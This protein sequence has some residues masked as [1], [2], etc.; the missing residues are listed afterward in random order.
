M[1]QIRNRWTGEVIAEG[2][3]KLRE[4][5]EKHR[6][7]LGGADL[8]EANLGGADLWGAN[9]R[10]ADLRGA[11][12]DFYYFPSIRTL[13]S[14]TL[15]N[16]SD[17]VTLELMRLDANAHPKPE[18][19]DEWAN[20]GDCPYQNEERWWFMPEKRGVW[21]P[22]KPT[23]KLSDLIL[24]ICRQEGWGIRNYLPMKEGR[25]DDPPL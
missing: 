5:A 17:E 4:L 6:A 19:F 24:E 1:T 16:V 21:K 10:G 11:K 18:L 2:D 12:I 13:S 20:G 9:L 23:M 8:G 7:N 22:G 3:I 15:R 25:A 14:M